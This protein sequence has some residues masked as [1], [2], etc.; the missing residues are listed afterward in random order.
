MAEYD[1]GGAVDVPAQE[2]DAD[3][4]TDVVR[5]VFADWVVN[6]SFRFASAMR[7][8]LKAP[9]AESSGHE[10]WDAL[11]GRLADAAGEGRL[12]AAQSL[13]LTLVGAF[14]AEHDKFE[15]RS[16]WP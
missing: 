5:E 6:P 11:R 10:M 16:A 12:R 13:P 14:L 7:R 4:P 2:I 8:A 3:P 15:E 9:S 1:N